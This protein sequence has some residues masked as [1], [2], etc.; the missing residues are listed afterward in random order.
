V[1]VAM[2]AALVLDVA[3]NL[4]PAGAVERSPIAAAA[5]ATRQRRLAAR[6]SPATSPR[7]CRGG[8]DRGGGDG[9]RAGMTSASAAEERS[10]R[11]SSGSGGSGRRMLAAASPARPGSRRWHPARLGGPGRRQELEP[12][13]VT[14]SARQRHQLAE[15]PGRRAR[16]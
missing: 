7:S 10:N 5:L 1:V 11:A 14:S 16:V 2:A 13:G 9:V 3:G 6:C 15:R 4:D 8:G 12:H